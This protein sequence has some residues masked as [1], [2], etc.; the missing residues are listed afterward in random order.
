MPLDPFEQKG[1]GDEGN[2]FAKFGA[3]GAPPKEAP[4]PEQEQ[5]EPEA[6][7]NPFAKFGAVGPGPTS[8]AG[9]FA[10]GI[11]RSVVPAIGSWPAVV[12][13][14]EVGGAAG[15]PLGPLGAGAGAIGGGLIGGLLASTALTKA[16]DYAVSKLPETWQE[17]LGQDDRQRRLDEQEHPVASFIGGIAPYALT[18]RPGVAAVEG[19]PENANVWQ[20]I[21]ANP[22]TR[23]LFGGLAMGGMELGQEYAE[24]DVDWRKIAVA[25]TFGLIFNR[26]TQLGETLTG[27]GVRGASRRG[28]PA[29]ER[30]APASRH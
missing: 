14:A 12:A 30:A 4:E 7:P 13:G 29:P 21:A 19:L 2:P 27:I 22:V 20:R 25:T 17:A 23:S 3:V 8:A 26:P 18:L 15:A 6:G 28:T 10:R 1:G 16:Q 9:A 5:E 11:E 24:G